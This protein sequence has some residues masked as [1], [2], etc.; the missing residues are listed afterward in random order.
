MRKENY[1]P[2]LHSFITIRSLAFRAWSKLIIYVCM[3]INT[4]INFSQEMKKIETSTFFVPQ[5]SREFE[6]SSGFV[7]A[8]SMRAL[9][10]RPCLC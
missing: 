9:C 3:Y 5:R 1:L 10:C 6:T 4:S 7:A 8:V 2:N